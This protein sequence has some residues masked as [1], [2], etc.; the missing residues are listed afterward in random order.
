MRVVAVRPKGPPPNAWRGL[1][2]SSAEATGDR[3]LLFAIFGH[4]P[5]H[6]RQVDEVSRVILTS[7]PAV[8]QADNNERLRVGGHTVEQD[9]FT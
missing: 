5:Q 9:T 2:P 4:K 3:A 8:P 7:C 6:L 1:A